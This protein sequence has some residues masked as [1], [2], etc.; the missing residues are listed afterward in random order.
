[1]SV[2]VILLSLKSAD[3]LMSRGGRVAPGQWIWAVHMSAKPLG[4]GHH[5]WAWASDPTR[6]LC[7]VGFLLGSERKHRLDSLL[8]LASESATCRA[9]TGPDRCTATAE[10]AAVPCGSHLAP[11]D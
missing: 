1:M 9:G 4:R 6:Q 10:G 8:C 7:V 3:A 5:C 2:W 11:T